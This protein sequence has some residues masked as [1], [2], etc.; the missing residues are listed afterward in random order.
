[1]VVLRRRTVLAA[2]AAGVALTG[3]TVGARPAPTPTTP[4][5]P[6]PLLAELMSERRLIAS[7]DATIARHP[8]LRGRLTGLRA[9]HLE[10]AAALA[11]AL[12]RPAPDAAGTAAPG[13]PTDPGPTS[14]P[15]DPSPTDPSPTGGASR[16]DGTGGASSSPGPG[17]PAVPGTPVAAVTALRAAERAAASARGTAALTATADRAALLAG[18]SASEATHLVVLA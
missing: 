10:H 14:G 11:T 6:D 15:T 7:Y 1:M 12:G 5:P 3:C 9:D 16:P 17:V 8:G 18:I 2:G 13:G 4:P